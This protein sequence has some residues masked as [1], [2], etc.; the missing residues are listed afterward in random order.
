MAYASVSTDRD[1]GRSKGVGIVQ[2]ETAHAAE[3][4]IEYMTGAHMRARA[5]RPRAVPHSR[6][7]LA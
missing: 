3:H 7:K 4:A 5:Q 6:R 1:T 2:F